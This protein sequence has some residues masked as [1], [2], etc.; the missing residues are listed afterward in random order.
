MEEQ[1]KTLAAAGEAPQTDEITFRLTEEDIYRALRSRGVFRTQGARAVVQTVL[2]AVLGAGFL[3]SYFAY[4][5]GSGLFLAAV[6]FAVVAMIWLVPWFG[7]RSRAR[8]AVPQKDVRIVLA[9]EGLAIGE[10]EGEWE[11]PLDGSGFCWQTEELLLLETSFGRM[12]VIPKR[13]FSAEQR[14]RWFAAIAQKTTP[15]KPKPKKRR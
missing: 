13:A 4:H 3:V 9:E 2:L 15:E 6:S 12:T 10:G 14:E 5:D 1:E 8:A 7:L 11:F